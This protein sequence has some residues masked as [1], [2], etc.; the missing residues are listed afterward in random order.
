MSEGYGFIDLQVNGFL[1]VDFSAPDLKETDL[2]NACFEII[3]KGTVAFL[4]TL[5]SSSFEVY[6]RNLPLII[7]LMK[8]DVLCNHILGIHLE[9]PFIA[10]SCAGAHRSEFISEPDIEYFN[11]LQE[12]AENKIK[13]LTLAP[14]LPGAIDLVKYA[15]NQGV[16][17][18]VGHSNYRPI[19]LEDAR[20]AGAV[21]LTHFGNAMPNKVDRHNN[22]IIHGLASDN[23]TAMIIADGH[24]LPKELVKV[25]VKNFGIENVILVSDSCPL[26][27]LPPGTYKA[28]NQ[29]V[30]FEESGRIVNKEEKHLAGSSST[31]LECVNNILKWDLGTYEECLN[32]SLYN[33]AKLLSIDATKIKMSSNVVFDC[34][35][36]CLKND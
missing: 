18:S 14:E 11:K 1:G 7:D 4:P 31:M 34:S 23:Y 20:H 6:Q 28:F 10:L 12:L 24:H 25:V 26:A 5:V 3:R 9:G 32:L 2:R 19:D 33:P 22:Q 17:I 16:A 27:G 36:F 30:I 35:Q 29:T 8:D 21:S 13:L 15:S